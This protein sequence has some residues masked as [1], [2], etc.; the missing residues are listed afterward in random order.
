MKPTDNIAQRPHKPM[1]F[2]YT[3]ENHFYMAEE[4]LDTIVQ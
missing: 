4:Y 1:I 3:W 2:P